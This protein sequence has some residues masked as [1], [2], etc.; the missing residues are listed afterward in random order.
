MDDVTRQNAS[1]VEES[2]AAATSLQE[3]ADHLARMVSVFRLDA[4]AMLR[5]DAASASAHA[6]RL[7]AA[8]EKVVSPAPRR[9]QPAART[10]GRHAGART[11]LKAPGRLATAGADAEE[12]AEF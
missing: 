1:L 6:P 8:P 11:A 7:P 4:A 12:W 10:P 3:Q 5:D 2:A 9:P